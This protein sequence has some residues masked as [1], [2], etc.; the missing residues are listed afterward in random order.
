MKDIREKLLKLG[1]LIEQV[2]IPDRIGYMEQ[3]ISLFRRTEVG[4][5]DQLREREEIAREQ[6]NAQIERMFIDYNNKVKAVEQDFGVESLF[7]ESSEFSHLPNGRS[8][9]LGVYEMAYKDGRDLDWIEVYKLFC[10]Y[11]SLVT[12]ALRVYAD[13]G[14]DNAEQDG[15]SDYA[16]A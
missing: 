14:T 3:H 12:G 6:A 2:E 9:F 13:G 4:T 8:L 10:K 11:E 15:R 7:Y 1:E 16:A 5:V